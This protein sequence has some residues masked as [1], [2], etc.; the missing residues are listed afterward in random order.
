MQ[1]QQQVL[2]KVPEGTKGCGA[3]AE[4]RFRKILVQSLGEV[5][6]GSGAEPR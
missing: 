1:L 4:V 6:E 3:A 2:G 5:P